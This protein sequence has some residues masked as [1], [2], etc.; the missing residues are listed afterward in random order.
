M[1]VH[2]EVFPS[3]ER[4]DLDLGIYNIYLFTYIYVH[5]Q[6]FPSGERLDLNLGGGLRREVALG[7]LGS[8]DQAAAAAVVHGHT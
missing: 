3:G 7:A 1:C 2:L 5:L 4:L 8:R 6:V